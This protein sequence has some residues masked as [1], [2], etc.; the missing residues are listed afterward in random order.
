[1]KSFLLTLVIWA[2]LFCPL[3]YGTYG[4]FLPP[5]DW[6]SALAI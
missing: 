3:W 2:G 1:M 4:E 5:A 6:I